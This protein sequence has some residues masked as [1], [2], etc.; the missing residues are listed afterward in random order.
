M[1]ELETGCRSDLSALHFDQ[2]QT[3]KRYT[4]TERVVLIF[5]HKVGSS[6]LFCSLTLFIDPLEYAVS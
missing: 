1:H 5:L 6:Q 4:N 3:N 2:G